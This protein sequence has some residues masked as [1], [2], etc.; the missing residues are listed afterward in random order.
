MDIYKDE[1]DESIKDPI[2]IMEKS[3]FKTEGAVIRDENGYPVEK[4]SLGRMRDFRIL[5]IKE[6]GELLEVGFYKPLNQKLEARMKKLLNRQRFVTQQIENIRDEGI[7][8]SFYKNRLQKLIAIHEYYL[9]IDQSP[10]AHKQLKDHVEFEAIKKLHPSQL[11]YNL[12][13][14]KQQLEDL[15]PLLLE[16]DMTRI[17]TEIKEI[18]LQLK[19]YESIQRLVKGGTWKNPGKQRMPLAETESNVEVGFRVVLPYTGLPVNKKYKVKW[20]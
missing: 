2:A 17:K 20:K 18:E 1:F 6:N 5:G 12:K 11:K 13:D 3:G 10:K 14:Y 9:E 4:D 19:N 15:D 16:K 7:D 8:V